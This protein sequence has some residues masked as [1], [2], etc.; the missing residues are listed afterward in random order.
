MGLNN[1]N[2]IYEFL[3][4]QNWYLLLR[5]A[6]RPWIFT[7]L[8]VTI[9]SGVGFE[10]IYIKRLHRYFWIIL[11]GILVVENTYLGWIYLNK[12]TSAPKKMPVKLIELLKS[13]KDIYRVFCTTKCISQQEAS[14]NNLQLIE[15]YNTLQQKNYYSH[16]WQL[17]GGYWDYYSLSL[18]PYGTYENYQLQPSAKSLGEYNTKYIISPYPLL[19]SGFQETDKIGNYIVYKNKLYKPRVEAPIIIYSPNLIRIDIS[20]YTKKNL[21]LSEVYSPGWKAYI[22]GKEEI[23]VQESPIHLRSV[24]IPKKGSYIDFRYYPD[25]YIYGK[26]ITIATILTLL[27]FFLLKNHLRISPKTKL[28]R[29]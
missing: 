29:H 27:L 22:D 7:S 13:D 25:S 3:I 15:G 21:T 24:D 19:D 1:K 28:M 6:T 26:N 20:S 18:P 16:T 17:M 9:L 12:K 4:K 10:Y 11:F 14:I 5:V 23:P 2:P 8:S